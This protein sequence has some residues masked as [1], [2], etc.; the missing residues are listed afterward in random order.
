MDVGLFSIYMDNEWFTSRNRRAGQVLK[1]TT[2]TVVFDKCNLNDNRNHTWCSTE[3]CLAILLAYQHC[4]LGDQCDIND[5]ISR[6]D[7]GVK[8][9]DS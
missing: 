8:K 4:A 6:H 7:C 9:E 5:C 3:Q 2:D 1:T